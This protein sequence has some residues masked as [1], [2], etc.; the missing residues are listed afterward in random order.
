VHELVGDRPSFVIEAIFSDP[1]KRP[2]E[3]Y[4]R[5]LMLPGANKNYV[6]DPLQHQRVLDANPPMQYDDMTVEYSPSGES[7][8]NRSDAGPGR[9]MTIAPGPAKPCRRPAR[10][11]GRRC[12]EVIRE[13]RIMFRPYR[14]DHGRLVGVGADRDVLS[15]QDAVDN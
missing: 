2:D 13:P 9:A 11:S 12:A 7:A 15:E 4:P 10:W 5:L 6:L 8:P 14:R 1:Q 3:E